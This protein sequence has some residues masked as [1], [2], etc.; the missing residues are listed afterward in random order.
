MDSNVAIFLLLSG[1]TTVAGPGNGLNFI[2]PSGQTG[3]DQ[4][5]E[6]D[7]IMNLYAHNDGDDD[8]YYYY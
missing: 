2:L 8:D 6:S 3:N 5:Y 7:K 1:N 4:G